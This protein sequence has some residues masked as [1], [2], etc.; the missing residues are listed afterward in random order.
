MSISFR[1]FPGATFGVNCCLTFCL[2]GGVGRGYFACY[3]GYAGSIPARSASFG[4]SVAE[5]RIVR[6]RLFPGQMIC[7]QCFF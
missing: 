2:A 5:R 4:S 3:A 7:R 6:T 1:L